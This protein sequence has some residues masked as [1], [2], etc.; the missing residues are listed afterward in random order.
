L[1]VSVAVTSAISKWWVTK[2]AAQFELSQSSQSSCLLDQ[3][4]APNGFNIGASR[5]LSN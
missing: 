5:D 2:L 1:P 3:S 4:K